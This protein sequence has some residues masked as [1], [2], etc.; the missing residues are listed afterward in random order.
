MMLVIE[1]SLGWDEAAGHNQGYR[2]SD[3]NELLMFELN[4]PPFS[5]RDSLSHHVF[6]RRKDGNAIRL[7]MRDADD[8]FLPGR[9][10]VRARMVLAA[11]HW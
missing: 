4:A 7:Y 9:S 1:D 11:W 8:A 6:A 10:K 3:G 2:W 5:V